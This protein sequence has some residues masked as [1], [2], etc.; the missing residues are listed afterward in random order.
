MLQKYKICFYD[1]ILIYCL[2]E[3]LFIQDTEWKQKKIEVMSKSLK[4]L[5][6]TFFNVSSTCWKSLFKPKYEVHSQ[7]FKFLHSKSFH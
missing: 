1:Y 3:F 2:F 4:V 7:K 5:K 6:T